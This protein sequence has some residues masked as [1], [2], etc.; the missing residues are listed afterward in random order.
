MDL[1]ATLS[2]EKANAF[3]YQLL[4]FTVT[5]STIRIQIVLIQSGLAINEKDLSS[6]ERTFHSDRDLEIVLVS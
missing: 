6:R 5:P 4:E 1:D 3:G 2:W